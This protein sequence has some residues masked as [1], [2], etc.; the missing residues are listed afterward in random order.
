MEM[1]ESLEDA[2]R[3]EV[4]EETGLEVGE[5]TLVDIYS[6]YEF[7]HEYPNGDRVF[8]VGAVY[9][10]TDVTGTLTPRGDET[11][12]QSFFRLDALPHNLG[13]V[14]RLVLERYRHRAGSGVMS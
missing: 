4:R 7:F 13:R 6:G 10:T 1:G 5:L 14:S 9:V 11:I 8:M 3:R 12:D 2:A